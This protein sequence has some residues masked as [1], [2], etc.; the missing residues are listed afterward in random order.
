LTLVGAWG[1]PLSNTPSPYVIDE[2]VFLYPKNSIQDT[3]RAG[4]RWKGSI[5]NSMSYSLVYYYTH[6]LS[7]PIPLYYDRVKL[8]DG[9]YD[10]N[11][12]EKLFLGFPRQHITGFSLEYT[13]E[14]PIGTVLRLETSFEPD[15][16]F[17]RTSTTARTRQDPGMP[18]R[19]HFETPKMFA[20]SYALVAMRPTMIRFLNPT[21]NFLLVLQFMHSMVPTLSATDRTDLVDIPGYNEMKVR[22][23]DLRLVF[24]ASTTYLHGFITP[25]VVVVYVLPDFDRPD[26]SPLGSGFVSASVN[27]RFGTHWRVDFSLTDFFGDDPYQGLGLF[28]DR[29]EINLAVT[30]QF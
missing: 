21:Q 18:S 9:S 11:H 12:L 16:T 2:K 10:N 27:F 22:K 30:C 4:F 7:P 14:S 19:V 8:P 17:P 24:A 28:R 1:L 3:M 15:R 29:D 13:L 23:H 26:V 6:Q 25:K 5:G 20:M